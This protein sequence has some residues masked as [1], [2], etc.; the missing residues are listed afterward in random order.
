M[1]PR[2][3]SPSSSYSPIPPAALPGVDVGAGVDAD[4]YTPVLSLAIGVSVGGETKDGSSQL[5]RESST[6][7]SPIPPAALPG[8]GGV[9]AVSLLAGASVS[10]EIKDCSSQPVRES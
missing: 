10:G 9:F 8:V 3:I 2:A 6:S 4:V 7:E 5:V 1:P